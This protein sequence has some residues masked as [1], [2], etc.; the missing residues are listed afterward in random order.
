MQGKLIAVL[1]AFATTK[2][3]ELAK[4]I[5]PRDIETLTFSS[6]KLTIGR[7]LAPIPQLKCVGG[8]ACGLGFDPL[9]V[10]CSNSGW[11]GR[12][13]QWKCEAEVEDAVKL[14]PVNV[15]C[16]GYNSSHDPYVLIG[17]CGLEYSLHK[18]SNY[19]NKK[20]RRLRVKN[21][22]KKV[23]RGLLSFILLP[24]SASVSVFKF[25]ILSVYGLVFALLKFI[26]AVGL[27]YLA[28]TYF[29]KVNHSESTIENEARPPAYDDRPSA[30]PDNS[31]E[32]LYSSLKL[33]RKPTAPF[34]PIN[35][36]KE[37]P[38]LSEFVQVNETDFN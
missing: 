17:S 10:Q 33:E 38:L 5:N 22:F 12:D 8:S 11:D 2:D 19:N 29:R 24:V 28:S 13:V 23:I 9:I 35:N 14:G 34:E 7:R 3:V 30:P 15:V 27:L 25:L 4:R 6:G 16:E 37:D 36:E 20:Y 26:F 18:T 32:G 1:A 21:G 31:S